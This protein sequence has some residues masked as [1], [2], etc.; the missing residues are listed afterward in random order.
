MV[1]H[2]ETNKQSAISAFVSLCKAL[3]VRY[4]LIED[5]NISTEIG[6]KKPNYNPKVVAAVARDQ[7]G[8]TTGDITFKNPSEMYAYFGIQEP[9][10]K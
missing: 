8:D 9:T 4:N 2:I 10:E 5:A 7:A 1:I 6:I 3:G